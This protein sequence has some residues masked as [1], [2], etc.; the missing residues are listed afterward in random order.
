MSGLELA[1]LQALKGEKGGTPDGDRV[2]VQFNPASLKIAFKIH[3]TG[4]RTPAGPAE[5]HTGATSTLSLDLHF[6]TADEGTTDKPV[7]VRTRTAIVARFV[8][9]RPPSSPDASQGPPRV[10]FQWGEWI[11]DGV[12]SALS[13]D[14]ELFS[15]SGVPLRAKTTVT[16]DGQ[17]PK[18][19]AL[20]TG[21]GS[22]N[23]A[24][25]S[26]P[27]G[28]FGA[29][30]GFSA[31]FGAS[32]GLGVS[33]GFSASIGGGAGVPA[34]SIGGGAGISAGV[35]QSF[36][37]A[38]IGVALDGE[39]PPDF[40]A[41]NGLDPAA[42]RALAAPGGVGLK[43][44]AGT[45]VAF[46][47]GAQVARG[48]GSATGAGQ[49]AID[50]TLRRV[51]G[52]VAPLAPRDAVAAGF[53]LARAG[54]VD[55]AM[56]TVRQE[57]ADA[58]GE[59]ERAAFGV[60]AEPARPSAPAHAPRALPRA[61]S[62]AP[63]APRPPLAD[64]RATSFGAGVPLRPRR[65]VPGAGGAGRVVLGR[66]APTVAPAPPAPRSHAGDCGCGCGGGGA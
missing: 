31:G 35:S 51:D 44:E 3:T 55:A 43:L 1:T 12:M 40:A 14:L 59:R 10:R 7:N 64:S 39:S 30:A 38:K 6:D 18:F 27:G 65:A 58:A 60:A 61:G 17:D 20:A 63:A 15:S 66:R 13:E 9:P 8:L 41:R 5:E 23:D 54:G 34:L 11:Y 57:R 52:P 2:S 50:A 33:A 62:T 42:W 49:P 28:G 29:S 36:G 37:S 4:A 19:E 21:P 25:A 26:V 16:I 22:A 45:E 47:S 32:A 53:A 46:P 24:G 56:Q 48:V